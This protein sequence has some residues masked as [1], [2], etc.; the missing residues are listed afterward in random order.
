VLED[1]GKDRQLLQISAVKTELVFSCSLVEQRSFDVARRGETCGH[2]T[3]TLAF[4]LEALSDPC[5]TLQ[6]R[7]KGWSVLNELTD[8]VRTLSDV[9][10]RATS[11]G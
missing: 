2:Q 1:Y 4:D 11:E 10:R 8:V 6:N 3:Q 5:Q 9:S 7:G